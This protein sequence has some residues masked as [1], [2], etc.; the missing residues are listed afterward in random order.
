MTTVELT[1]PAI[2]AMLV[3]LKSE[4]NT[5]YF[6]QL[7]AM[8]DSGLESTHSTMFASA[9]AYRDLSAGFYEARE[10]F[11]HKSLKDRF[12]E[13]FFPNRYER[14]AIVELTEK[15][16]LL[17][18]GALVGG[19]VVS[20]L[21]ENQPENPNW[22]KLHK[23][24]DAE[25]PG[26]RAAFDVDG[27]PDVAAELA[28]SRIKE[29]FLRVAREAQTQAKE[30]AKPILP[31]PPKPAELTVAPPKPEPVITEPTTTPGDASE[32]V[33]EITTFP[34]KR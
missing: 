17:L 25:L 11:A 24:L 9:M 21:R 26:L 19:Y 12:I 23:E 6:Y 29:Y 1:K 18:G 34:T 28:K 16:F 7:Q 22:I 5:Q 20:F 10:I 33:P 2:E 8:D 32:G 3:L 13:K 4:L 30:P 31:A 27:P 15:D 14:V